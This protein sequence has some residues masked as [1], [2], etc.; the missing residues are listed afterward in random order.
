MIQV[1]FNASATGYWAKF[2]YNLATHYNSIV[3]VC[4]VKSNV[5]EAVIP[6]KD[7][8][9]ESFDEE[10]FI[11]ALSKGVD[12]LEGEITLVEDYIVED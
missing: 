12:F 3:R 8:T 6:N 10:E 5:Y 1:T 11:I 2:Q 7:I 4:E 9:S